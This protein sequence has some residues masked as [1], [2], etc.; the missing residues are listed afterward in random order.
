MISFG[1]GTGTFC[2]CVINYGPIQFI[3]VLRCWENLVLAML[4]EQ[5]MV[6]DE[7]C[8]AVVSI[9]SVSTVPIPLKSGLGMEEILVV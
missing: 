2:Q 9:R 4:G 1:P 5:F 6:G 8:G 3:L 7:I